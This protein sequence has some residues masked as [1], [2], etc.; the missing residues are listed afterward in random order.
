M[1]FLKRVG[2]MPRIVDVKNLVL[3]PLGKNSKAASGVGQSLLNISGLAV[4]YRFV[5]GAKGKA[6][7]KPRANGKRRRRR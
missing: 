5:K 1:T 4:T 7:G 3:A 6:K 2:E